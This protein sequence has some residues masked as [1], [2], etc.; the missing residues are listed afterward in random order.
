M[1]EANITSFPA[2]YTIFSIAFNRN[3][4]LSIH[5]LVMSMFCRFFVRCTTLSIS[6]SPKTG[7]GYSYF[8]FSLTEISFSWSWERWGLVI[9]IRALANIIFLCSFGLLLF[10]PCIGLLRPFCKLFVFTVKIFPH[11]QYPTCSSFK[12]FLI[13]ICIQHTVPAFIDLWNQQGSTK[14]RHLV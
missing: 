7:L 1:A 3:V 10:F 4:F 12:V 8:V 9:S 6:L 5:V 13:L 14:T 2:T 11:L